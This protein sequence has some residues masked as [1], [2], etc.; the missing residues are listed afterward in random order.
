GGIWK[1]TDDG[2][3][4]MPVDDFM[5]NM[6]VSTIVF[7]PGNP[8]VMYA[9]SGEY[10]GGNGLIGA[11]IFKSVDGG[12]TWSQLAATT[13]SEFQWVNKLAMSADGRVLLAATASGLFRSVDG[14]ASFAQVLSST[15]VVLDVVS[16]PTDSA[17]AIA[18]GYGR[19]WITS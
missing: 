2:A 14:G 18:A 9:G 4:W 12:T 16:H 7:Q 8:S 10:L 5:A 1:S 6:N 17:R 11:G 3:S 19:A 13:G 15:I